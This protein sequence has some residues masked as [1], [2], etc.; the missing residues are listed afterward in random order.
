MTS[1]AETVAEI[2]AAR[3][4]VAGYK[5]VDAPI[6]QPAR[7]YIDQS[8]EDLRR[9]TYIFTGPDGEELCLRPE[10]T[11]PVAR[12]FL[13]R[14]LGGKRP[15][16]LAYRGRVFRQPPAGSSRPSEYDQ[17]GVE[18]FGG[19]NA[20][21]EDA[22]ALAIAWTSVSDAGVSDLRLNF[23]DL[24]LFRALVD[25]LDA[26]DGW[27]ARM[28]RTF[29]HPAA[30]QRLLTSMGEPAAQDETGLFAALAGLKPEAAQEVVSDVLEL[31]GIR[32]VGGRT[33]DEIT[34]RFLQKAGD[35]AMAALP[36]PVI[37]SILAFL[38][39]KD[40]PDAAIEALRKTARDAG[41]DIEDALER[42]KARF[43]RMAEAGIDATGATFSASFG[44][45]F[46][47]YT[48]FV[49]EIV[50]PKLEA[51]APLAAGGRYDTLLRRLGAPE[52][53][54]AV[55]CMLR[56]DRIAEAAS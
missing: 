4:A 38:N 5:W 24:G 12:V 53:M 46:D 10:Q 45:Q 32:T 40:A 51:D 34:E 54:P 18:R 33:V 25:A 1:S 26:S 56:P 48:D 28:K 44:R 6:L 16:R 2:I 11:I 29:A 17:M 21:G 41:A 27:R 43:A 8:G 39:V 36:A 35:A 55:G 31:A 20:H 52:D 15:A 7:I 47:Y 30:F 50:S 22:E 37:K 19:E 49:F 14:G 9:R 23:G 42:A 3:I 13:E